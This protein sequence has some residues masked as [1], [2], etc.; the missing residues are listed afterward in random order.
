MIYV[1]VYQPDQ[2]YY[3]ALMARLSSPLASAGRSAYGWITIVIGETAISFSGATAIRVPPIGGM[4]L[5]VSGT[6]VIRASGAR[7]II[8]AQSR[9]ITA[10]G[11]MVFPIT[12]LG[13]PRQAG[14]CP[15][16]RQRD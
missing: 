3:D 5:H 9:R 14:P 1:P 12:D 13:L 15:I 7:I 6:W 4:N 11:A 16:Q 10:T 2:V 8:P